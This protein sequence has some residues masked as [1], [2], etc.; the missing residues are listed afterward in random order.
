[1]I[2]DLYFISGLGADARIFQRLELPSNVRV[3][4]ISWPPLSKK[5]TLET[6]CEKIRSQINSDH[7]FGIV[8]LSFGGIIA[9]ELT[10]KINP[11]L[12]IILSSI[13]NKHELPLIYQ[14]CAKLR[15][16]K[17]IPTYF[18]NKAY[19]FTSWAFG[20]EK[21]SDKALLKSI[22]HFTPGPFIKWALNEIINWQN[23]L[24]PEGI[25]HIHG[26]SDRLFPSGLV[27][28]D[29]KV[30]GAG[31]LMVFTHPK[32]ISQLIRQKLPIE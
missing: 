10:K 28:P 19:P 4:H 7:E 25:F 3:H 26:D 5:E 24:R 23:D 18:M 31:H 1:M 6:Y 9:T 29:I 15:L 8:G 13:S 21:N 12:T 32:I 30:E 16:N 22:I 20:I 2:S 11:K 14:I 17:V 27:K